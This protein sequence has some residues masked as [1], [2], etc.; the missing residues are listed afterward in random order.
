MW[1]KL[2]L[3]HARGRWGRLDRSRLS[4]LREPSA[5]VARAWELTGAILRSFR[6]AVSADH[7]RFLVVALPAAE[8][9]YDDVWDA[10]WKRSGEDA[11]VFDRDAPERRLRSMC[12]DAGV[13][14]VSLSGAF[15]SAAAASAAPKATDLFWQGIGH[16]NARGN[17]VAAEAIVAALATDAR[18]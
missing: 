7:A 8:M 16:L 4:Y 10:L 2:Q 13:T 6:D 3:T 9:V 15:R 12:E 1:Q 5:D 17:E 18:P 11:S 14:I